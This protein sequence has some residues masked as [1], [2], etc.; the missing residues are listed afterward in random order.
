MSIYLCILAFSACYIAARRSLVTGLGVVLLVGYAYGIVRANVP[1]TFSHFIFDSA[2][3]G[4]YGAQLFRKLTP[5]QQWRTKSLR[6]W[7]EFLIGWPVLLFIIPAQALLVQLVGLRAAIFFLPFILIGASLEPEERFELASWLA[8][9][10]LVVLGVAVAEFFLGLEHFFPKNPLTELIYKSKDLVGYTAYR[11]PSTFAN[12]HSYAGTMVMGMPL[13]IGAA[14]QTR[15][16]E[17]RRTVLVAG[18]AAAILGVLLAATRTHFIGAALIILVAAFSIRSRI[19]HLLGW[20]LM[21]FAIGWIVSGEQRLQRFTELRDTQMVTDRIAG[22]V[23]IEFIE[24]ARQYPFGN[25]LGSGGTSMPYWL[26]AEITTPVVM[27]NEYV[28]IM[29]EEGLLGLGLWVAFVLWLACQFRT[30]IEDPWVVGRRVAW[31]A[32]IAY[33]LGGLLGIGLLTAVPQTALFLLGVGW[34]GAKQPA[35]QFAHAPM[36]SELDQYSLA[37]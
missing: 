22:S 9:L 4:F 14:L 37:K 32:T 1:E 35:V 6:A 36:L 18:L 23:N 29:L 26:Q 24:L 13:M 34:V 17:L 12:A 25:G 7:L 2:V 3:V 15:K 8:V 21:L 10:N 16:H 33:F 5:A 30:G 11:I 20:A 19:A 31:T 27:E 28:R